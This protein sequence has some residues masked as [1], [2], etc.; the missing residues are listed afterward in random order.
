MSSQ[1]SQP[2]VD[3]LKQHV[4]E[5]LRLAR[6]LGASEA[7]AV[8]S[9]G[10]GLTVNVRV[11]EVETLEFHRDQGMAVTVYFGKRKGSASTSDLGAAALEES[12]RKACTLAR[13][14]T[15]DS[16]AGLADPERLA[17][18]VPDLDLHHPWALD[19]D[20]AIELA[21]RCEVAALDS[22]ARITN[23]EG[24]GVSSHEGCRA[25]GN[26]HGFLQGYRDTYHSL[27]CAVIASHGEQMERDVDYTTARHPDALESA[28]QIG[29]EAARRACA[30][31]GAVKIDTRTAPVLYPARLARG[32][33]GHLVGA[34][35]GGAL[36]RKSSF[37]LDSLGKPVM[38]SCVSIDERPHL[39]RGLAS[40]PYDDDGV[41]TADRRLVEGGVLQGY[42]L[43]SYSARRLG[44][45]STGNAGGSHNLLVADT[46]A[47]YA[48][49]LAEMQTGFLVTELMGSGVN[50]VTGDYSRGAAG[51]WV[52]GGQLQYPVSEVTVAGNLKDMFQDIIGIG[53]DIDQRGGIRSGSILVR[54]MTIAGS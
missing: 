4:A 54:Q 48:D 18:S 23:S 12:V 50:P 46:G 44:M 37:L 9:F 28:V 41:A 19:A 32:L 43:G 45:Q 3:Q 15:E 2:G 1:H 25:S 31:L 29:R 17:R 51:F 16:Y 52:E 14:T 10:T 39:P 35:S 24:A 53:T 7:Q 42:F 11:R 5:V 6:G 30:R 8:A 38:A 33:I 36:Y 49:L 47:S 34:V 40:A 21:T 27:S 20:A 26:S 13:Y 22:D